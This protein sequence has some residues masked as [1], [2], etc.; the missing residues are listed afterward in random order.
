MF[1]VVWNEGFAVKN[2]ARHGWTGCGEESVI[3]TEFT[4]RHSK[5]NGKGHDMPVKETGAETQGSARVAP[6]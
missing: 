6:P 3:F 1:K 4:C 5:G 2:E